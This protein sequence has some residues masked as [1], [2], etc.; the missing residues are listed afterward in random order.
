MYH[1]MM[2]FIATLRSKYL[3]VCLAFLN[4][5]MFKSAI[6]HLLY[7]CEHIFYFTAILEKFTYLQTSCKLIGMQN[8]GKLWLAICSPTAIPAY[9]QIKT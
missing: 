8:I 3:E 1:L 9:E 6:H 4:C 2:I 5:K 7:H